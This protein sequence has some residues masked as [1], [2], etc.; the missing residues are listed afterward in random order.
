MDPRNEDPLKIY[1]QG[2]E[3]LARNSYLQAIAIRN[4]I[5]SSKIN[6]EDRASIILHVINL[7]TSAQNKKN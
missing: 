4:D 2:V 1:K 3:K 6:P 7:L 5:M